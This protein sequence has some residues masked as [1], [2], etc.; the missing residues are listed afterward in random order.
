MGKILDFE[1]YNKEKLCT[2]V[3]VDYNKQEV[4]VENFTNDII[5]QAFGKQRVTIDSIDEFFRERVFEETRV[6]KNELLEYFGLKVF[7]A[8]AIARKTHGLIAS[9]T[10]WLRFDNEEFGY[11]NVA[12]RKGW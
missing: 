1:Y 10:Y 3:H 7:D 9:D 2:R 4:L 8:E 5:E 11:K 6:D 12:E